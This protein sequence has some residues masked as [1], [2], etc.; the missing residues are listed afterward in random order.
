MLVDQPRGL[1]GVMPFRFALDVAVLN[2]STSLHPALPYLTLPCESTAKHPKIPVR[3]LVLL[4]YGAG[5]LFVTRGPPESSL[6][7]IYCCSDRE[8]AASLPLVKEHAPNLLMGSRRHL[9][10]VFDNTR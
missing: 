9:R 4:L 10:L 6:R 2:H 7:P 1:Y 8:F 5:H 3:L